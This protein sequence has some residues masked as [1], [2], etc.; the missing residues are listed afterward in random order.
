MIST[1]PWAEKERRGAAE[2]RHY[3]LSLCEAGGPAMAGVQDGRE[4]VRQ[5]T[6][7]RDVLS[8]TGTTRCL[9]WVLTSG[10]NSNTSSLRPSHINQ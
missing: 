7:V 9:K 2:A 8:A 6:D 5:D 10:M 3:Q 4:D 1:N